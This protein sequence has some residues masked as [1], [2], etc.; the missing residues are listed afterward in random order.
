MQICIR[1]SGG[2]QEGWGNIYRISI[3]IQYI[4]HK[5]NLNY[6][7]LVQG[8]SKIFSYFDNQKIK[9]IKLRKNIGP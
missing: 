5:N 7:L 9:Y 6:I 4:F 2:S 3:I 8:N 1:T